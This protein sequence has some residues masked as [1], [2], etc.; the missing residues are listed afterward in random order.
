MTEQ[1]QYQRQGNGKY[2]QQQGTI[3]VVQQRPEEERRMYDNYQTAYTSGTSQE[4]IMRTGREISQ[5]D[6]AS[7]MGMMI[8]VLATVLG[9]VVF[10]FL[11][12]EKAEK[13]H[14]E[15]LNKAISKE[16]DLKYQ[17]MNEMHRSNWEELKTEKEAQ[18]EELQTTISRNTEVLTGTHR[19]VEKL[20]ESVEQLTEII[21]ADNIKIVGQRKVM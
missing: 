8:A 6:S 18:I 17:D 11:R 2:Y 20:S 4:H 5:M 12:A 7:L 14:S 3:T 19:S 1:E 10:Y 15:S 9:A 13:L 21:R 16:K